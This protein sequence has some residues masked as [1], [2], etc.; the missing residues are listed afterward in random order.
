MGQPFIYNMFQR[1][2]LFFHMTSC[3]FGGAIFTIVTGFMATF[4]VVMGNFLVVFGAG[5]TGFTFPFLTCY[6]G[7]LR[8]VSIFGVMA[9]IA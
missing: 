8:A 3:T 1:V 5:M 2:T 6:I 9:L 7:T 4:T